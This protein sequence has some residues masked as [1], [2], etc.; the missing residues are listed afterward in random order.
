MMFKLKLYKVVPESPVDFCSDIY[1]LKT[2]QPEHDATDAPIGH[3]G[4]NAGKDCSYPCTSSL[5]RCDFWMRD[6]RG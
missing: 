6:Y 4:S 1:S 3:V 5:S 2:L